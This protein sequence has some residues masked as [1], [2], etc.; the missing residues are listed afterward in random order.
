MSHIMKVQLGVL[1]PPDAL[2][3]FPKQVV[4]LG[5]GALGVSGG[6]DSWTCGQNVLG[7]QLLA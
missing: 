3:F 7:W 6:L 4:A 1:V 2:G 5:V